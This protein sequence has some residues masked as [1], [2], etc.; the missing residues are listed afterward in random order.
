MGLGL[1][2]N[3]AHP[4]PVAVQ[5]PKPANMP[6]FSKMKASAEAS[7]SAEIER[8]CGL[9]A[10]VPLTKEDVDLVSR[11]YMSES[12]YSKGERLRPE[13]AQAMVHYNDHGGIFVTLGVGMGK[14]LISFMVANDCYKKIITRRQNGDISKEARILLVVQA[15][16][17]PK[18]EN[19]IPFMRGF[20]KELPPIYIMKGSNKRHRTMLAKSGRRGVYVCSYHTLS[21]KDATDILEHIKPSCIICDEAQNVAGT[22]DSARAKRFRGYVNQHQ[23]EIVP[24]SGTMTRKSVMEY[25][26]LS[27]AALGNNNFLPN[28][29]HMAEEWSAVLDSSAPSMGQFRNDLRPRPGPISHLTDWCAEHF[30]DTE[31]PPNLVGFRR[32]FAQRMVTAPGVICSTEEDAVGAGLVFSN[33]RCEGMEDRQGWPRLQEHLD[34]LINDF[35]TPSGEELTCAMNVWGYRY[36]MEATGFYYDLYWRDVDK[37]AELRKI[38]MPEAEDI[39]ERSKEYHEKHKKYQAA[40]RYWLKNS[41]RPKLDTPALVGLNMRNHGSDYVGNDL[42]T[43]WTTWKNAAFEGM[44]VRQ[45]RPVRVCDFK[46]RCVADDVLANKKD[47]GIVWY[48]HSEM[49]FWAMDELRA[50][51]LDPIHCPRGDW[52]N[53]LL[54]DSAKLKGKIIVAS[55]TAHGT[56]KDLQHG[57]HKNYY[58][59]TPIS[60]A[61]LEQNLGRTHRPGQKRGEVVSMFYLSTDFDTAHFNVL[62]N[63]TAYMQQTT[64]QKQK[65]LIG[66]YTFRPRSIPYTALQELGA[67]VGSKADYKLLEGIVGDVN[68]V[69]IK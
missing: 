30:P 21:S 34:I 32:A 37:M 64:T 10:T 50:R 8:I 28:S 18:C 51:G 63:D 58:M 53:K 20:L 9:P 2:K 52:S 27:K 46:V 66:S 43:S 68:K 38:S 47:G 15:N 26:F 39:L 60:A 25:F 13:Q 42:Y 3:K 49:G 36:Q 61:V 45:S 44:E 33:N 11:H 12:A 19:D 29:T 31:L 4:A 16:L 1:L 7:L 54:A 62:L 17:I 23:P 55:T 56:G 41:S 57:F 67:R 6:N 69:A 40:L 65:L 59:Q 22:K 35:Q 48:T 14:T 5:S 24:L